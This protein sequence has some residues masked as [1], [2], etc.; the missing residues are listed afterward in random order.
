MLI[1]ISRLKGVQTYI[2]DV[3]A[4]EFASYTDSILYDQYSPII[5]EL[6]FIY[7]HEITKTTEEWDNSIKTFEWNTVLKEIKKAL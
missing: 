7:D 3:I 6:K 5:D 4:E 1:H 2:K